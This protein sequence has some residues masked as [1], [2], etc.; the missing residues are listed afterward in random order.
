[1]WVMFISSQ[2][3]LNNMCGCG[4]TMCYVICL[5]QPDFESERIISQSDAIGGQR[6][7]TGLDPVVRFAIP[8]MK[9]SW[10]MLGQLLGYQ[11]VMAQGR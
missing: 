5:M 9:E 4:Y 7:S 2:S 10:E 11:G 6:L 3:S 8:I 1:M